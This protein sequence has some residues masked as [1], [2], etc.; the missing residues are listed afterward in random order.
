MPLRRER[1]KLGVAAALVA[2]RRAGEGGRLWSAGRPAA[3]AGFMLWVEGGRG[4][5]TPR[6]R[7]D[8]QGG[9]AGPLKRFDLC[10]DHYYSCP[11]AK[12]AGEKRGGPLSPFAKI[13]GEKR[14]VQFLLLLG[15]GRRAPPD[16]LGEVVQVEGVPDAVGRVVLKQMPLC[17][18]GRGLPRFQVAREE[19]SVLYLTRQVPSTVLR[20][21]N[22]GSFSWIDLGTLQPKCGTQNSWEKERKKKT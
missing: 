10:R 7:R 2:L 8:L 11:L 22:T 9:Q 19:A 18:G 20:M 16:F 6:G 3:A 12:I 13:A 14:A 5:Q 21:Q 1:V 4:Q 15:T 17:S